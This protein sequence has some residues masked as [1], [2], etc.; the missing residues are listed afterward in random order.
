[1]GKILDISSCIRV[2]KN[3]QEVNISKL[4]ILGFLQKCSTHLILK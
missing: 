1:M 2:D 3:N 4:N